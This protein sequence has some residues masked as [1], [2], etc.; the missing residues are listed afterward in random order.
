MEHDSNQCT[1]C[2]PMTYYPC[3]YCGK[4]LENQKSYGLCDNE[5]EFYCDDCNK[6][7]IIEEDAAYEE[8]NDQMT[9]GA[10]M[11]Q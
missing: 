11:S 3:P 10:T 5:N 4:T 2:F 1:N 6:T 7:Y 9:N 8:P